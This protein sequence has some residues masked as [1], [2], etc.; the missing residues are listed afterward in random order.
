VILN[1]VKDPHLAVWQ[2]DFMKSANQRAYGH[3]RDL[4][5]ER[6]TELEV[7]RIL[8]ENFPSGF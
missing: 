3:L 5:E 7:T 8:R 2:I 6:E 4:E 1:R